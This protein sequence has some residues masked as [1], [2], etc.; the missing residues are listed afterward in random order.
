M[1]GMPS[2]TEYA[3]TLGV[4]RS[5][6]QKKIKELGLRTIK[7][8]R[9]GRGKAYLPAETC[10]IL[11]DKLGKKNLPKEVDTDELM[12]LYKAQVEPL[13]AANTSLQAQVDGLI[14][15]LEVANA[16]ALETGEW[17]QKAID[18]Q[19]AQVEALQRENDQLRRDL[20]LSRALEGF[21][22]PWQRDRIKAQYLLPAQTS[23]NEGAQD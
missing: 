6:V 17:A 8:G 2:I 4:S 18:E 14:R 15:Q 5:S 11:A 22:W 10:S 16:A 23:Q 13:K 3:D 9:D 20:Q 7:D 1:D 21:H 12:D 19:K